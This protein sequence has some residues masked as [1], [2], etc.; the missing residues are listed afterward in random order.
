MQQRPG[1]RWAVTGIIEGFYGRPWTWDERV[2]VMRWC[3]ERG[4][5]HY[6]YAPKD[7]DRHRARWREPYDDKDLDGFRRLA[8]EGGL[9]VGYAIAPGLS[10]DYQSTSDRD[11]LAA[12]LDQVIDIGIDL[13]LL[14]LDDIP[15][16]DGL[17]DDHAELTRWLHDHLAG[18]AELLLC[19]TEYVGTTRTPY[20]DALA[21][22]VPDAVAI[23]WTG[24]AVVN[25]AI[26]AD[27]ARARAAALGGRLPLLWDNFPVN[28]GMMADRLHLGPLWGRDPE[29]AVLCSGYLAN[30]MVQP[31]A[32]KLPLA[33]VA[34]FVRGDDPLDAWA[35][36]AAASGLRV[37]AEACDGGVPQALVQALVDKGAGGSWPEAARPLASWLMAASS[38]ATPGLDGEVAPWLEQVHQE[39]TVGLDALR[40]FQACRPSL[41][42]DADGH[43]RAAAPDDD[44][45]IV[46][47]FV[48]SFRW[49]RVRRAETS[50]MGVRL[51]L[52]PALGQRPDGRW[53]FR[54]ESVIEDTNAVDALVR[55][56]FANLAEL[57]GPEPLVVE[58]DGLEVDLGAD[59]SFAA[60]AGA[61]VEARCGH[62]TTRVR[63]PCSPV[64]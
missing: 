51:G 16:R 57:T 29:L 28:D 46:F 7:D 18:R 27:D 12:K 2:D 31:L 39:A 19:P 47:A 15:F 13:V 14:A 21:Q 9:R 33:S 25:D 10:I 62:A 59:G 37:F 63:A 32:S 38:C 22:G 8:G 20:L 11:A 30:P 34:A 5:T 64:V 6:L 52:R 41:V 42:I 50:V 45:A 56:A 55:L 36:Q 49:P 48:L 24:M 61:I 3:H 44:A 4:M 54:R 1:E 40:L 58:V 60:E 17:G 35:H 23:A 26:T 43:G 53:S